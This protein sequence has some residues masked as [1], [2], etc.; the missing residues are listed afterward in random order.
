MNRKYIKYDNSKSNMDKT[1]D[2]YKIINSVVIENI[3]CREIFD[4]AVR[5]GYGKPLDEYSEKS[6][7]AIMVNDIRH[8]CSNYDQALKQ[9]YRIHRSDNDYAQYKNSV[10]EKIANAYPFLR[11]EC[12]KQKRKFDMIKIVTEVG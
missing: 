8:N 6:I 12:V 9:V 11:D 7:N 2:F 3:D 1:I 4:N 5:Y 10:L